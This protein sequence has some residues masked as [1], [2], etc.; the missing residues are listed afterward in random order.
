MRQAPSHE[1]VALQVSGAQAC[2]DRREPT[3]AVAGGG[4]GGAAPVTGAI[5]APQSGLVAAREG[6]TR[7]RVVGEHGG[8][9]GVE[10][11]RDR[12]C[13]CGAG[14]SNATAAS[15]SKP[16]LAENAAAGGVG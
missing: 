16:P 8:G 3:L 2:Q 9:F 1:V 11:R 6:G 7:G 4:V 14:R 12:A 13:A 5:P 10:H 15:T